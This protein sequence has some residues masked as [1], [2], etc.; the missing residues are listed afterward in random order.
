M[1]IA[2]VGVTNLAHIKYQVRKVV[3]WAFKR[4]V[5]RMK[6]PHCPARPEQL[7]TWAWEVEK[8]RKEKKQEEEEEEQAREQERIGKEDEEE[9]VPHRIEIERRV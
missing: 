2:T 7:Y 5:R 8:Q 9:N 1:L 4:Y 6:P 3:P